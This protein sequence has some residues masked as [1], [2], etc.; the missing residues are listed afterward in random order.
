M[1]NIKKKY[2][3]NFAS[4]SDN[5]LENLDCKDFKEKTGLEKFFNIFKKKG[6]SFKK[7]QQKADKKRK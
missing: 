2:A 5:I 1:C 6:K 7:E 4:L 3:K